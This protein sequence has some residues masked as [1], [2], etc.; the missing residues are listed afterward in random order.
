VLE[1][2]LQHRSYLYSF[3]Y[4]GQHTKFGYGQKVDYPFPGG[5][6]YGDVENK[7]G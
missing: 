4:Y 7:G 1:N 3:N 6:F 5:K 2:S